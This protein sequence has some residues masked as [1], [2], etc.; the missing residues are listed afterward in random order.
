MGVGWWTRPCYVSR[1]SFKTTGQTIFTQALAV[2]TTIIISS[3]MVIGVLWLVKSCD[4]ATPQQCV[5]EC[6]ER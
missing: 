3:G 4:L 1:M 6:G 2:V 5:C